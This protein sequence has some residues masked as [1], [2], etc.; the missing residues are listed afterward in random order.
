MTKPSRSRSKGR[1]A[2]SGEALKAVDIARIC[3]KP[4]SVSRQIAASEPPATITSASPRAMSRPASPS[5]WEPVA[6]AVTTEW[7]GPRKPCLMETAPAALLMRQ[8]GM[9]MGETR[10]APCSCSTTAASARPGS[11]PMPEPSSTPVRSRSS[12]SVGRQPA[13]ASACS[14]AARAKST[15]SSR[16]LSSFSVA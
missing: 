7:L 6:Q 4:A 16:R 14:L 12:R 1:E 10:R 9:K 13:S 5:A 15:T 2:C 11:P 8:P 3:E